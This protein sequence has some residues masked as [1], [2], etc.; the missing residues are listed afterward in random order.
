MPTSQQNPRRLILNQQQPQ[1]I[2][3]VGGGLK[4]TDM[5]IITIKIARHEITGNEIA[6]RES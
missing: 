5:K 1:S 3:W 6:R 2:K 4:M